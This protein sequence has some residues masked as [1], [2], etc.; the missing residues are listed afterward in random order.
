MGRKK[1]YNTS[2]ELREA[3]MVKW[4]RWYEKNKEDHNTH[5]MIEYYEKQLKEIQEK[6]SEL[7]KG[8]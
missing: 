4:K 2:E 3:N 5:R 8:N 7:R 1:K 6:L